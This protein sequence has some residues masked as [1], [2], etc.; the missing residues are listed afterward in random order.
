MAGLGHNQGPTMEAGFGWRKHCWSKAR[1]D[2]IPHLPLEIVRIRMARAKE[3]G[4]DYKTY[5]SVRSSSGRDV[6]A[7]LFSSNALRLAAS[8]ADLPGDRAERLKHARNVGHIVAAHRPIDPN[9]LKPDFDAL[10]GISLKGADRAPLFTESWSAMR[11]RMEAL[12]R[13]EGLP[14]DG[15]VLVGETSFEREWLAAG[16]FGGYIPADTYFTG[17]AGAR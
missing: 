17:P 5:A 14:R 11:E 13:R 8:A 7:F 16:R 10:H 4:L 15:I 2:L 3:I 6:I 12:V 1:A 9:R